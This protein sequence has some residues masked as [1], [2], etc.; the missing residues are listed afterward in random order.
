MEKKEARKKKTAEF[1]AWQNLL[2]KKNGPDLE[3]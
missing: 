2:E 1:G 3:N